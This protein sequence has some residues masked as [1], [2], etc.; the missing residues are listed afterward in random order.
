MTSFD[1]VAEDVKQAIRQIRVRI[2]QRG[3]QYATSAVATCYQLVLP[4]LRAFGWDVDDP[5][6]TAITA[7]DRGE[8]VQIVRRS[9]GGDAILLEVSAHSVDRMHRPAFAK[10]EEYLLGADEPSA[11]AAVFT[12]GDTWVVH[13]RADD[14]RAE[15]KR[16]QRSENFEMGYWLYARVQ[17]SMGRG[18]E[19]PRPLKPRPVQGWRRLSEDLPRDVK[20]T[21]I[22]FADGVEHEVE[23]FSGANAQI[24]RYLMRTGVLTAVRLPI[25]VTS[26]TRLV[27]NS[28]PKHLNGEAFYTPIQISDRIWMETRTKTSDFVEHLVRLFDALGVDKSSVEFEFG[29][30]RLSPVPSGL[31]DLSEPKF[32]A[33]RHLPPR[34]V[35]DH[36]GDAHVTRHW[37]DLLVV[38]SNALIEDRRITRADCP[39]KT[40]KHRGRH[41]INTVPYHTNGRRFHNPKQISGGYYIEANLYVRD[42]YR[43]ARFLLQYADIPLTAVKFSLDPN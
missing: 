39:I 1:D 20:P 28:V 7:T 24:G 32:K 9:A 17:P 11:S 16:L 33:N 3:S 34:V 12:D 6:T 4:V 27:F 14:W 25:G 36:C 41:L 19:P 8:R 42:C 31:L 26:Q 43:Y 5:A 22:R 30:A 18:T 40:A 13:R 35:I 37:I 21:R 23:T 38:T 10:V 29:G 2:E 15:S